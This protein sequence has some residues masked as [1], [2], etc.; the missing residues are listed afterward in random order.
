MVSPMTGRTR[1][2]VYADSIG[3]RVV[4]DAKMSHGIA[5]ETVGD[6]GNRSKCHAEQSDSSLAGSAPTS[7]KIS[8]ATCYVPRY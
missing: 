5:G 6:A 4:R 8:G 3:T 1:A 7:T 2:H